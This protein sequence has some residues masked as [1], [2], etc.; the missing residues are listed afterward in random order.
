VFAGA[1]RGGVGG[2]GAV[3]RPVAGPW[4]G[5]PTGAGLHTAAEADGAERILA[6]RYARGEIAED[7]YRAR[8]GVLRQASA[9]GGWPAQQPPQP[10]FTAA[11]ASTAP[12]EPQQQP[13]EQGQE[14]S[15]GQSQS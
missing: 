15:Q 6:E 14:P 8:L 12:P 10:P 3:G 13:Q 9:P 7:E 4:Y 1:R 2:A 11:A 5:P